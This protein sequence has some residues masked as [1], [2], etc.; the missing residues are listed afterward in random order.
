MLGGTRGRRGF[1]HGVKR[2][3]NPVRVEWITA[4]ASALFAT[5]AFAANPAKKAIQEFN[6]TPRAVR[7]DHPL[8]PVHH[9]DVP[10]GS[11]SYTVPRH[12]VAL[13]RT[14]RV[15][16][17]E[18]LVHLPT[19][20]ALNLESPAGDLKNRLRVTIATRD[21]ARI[22]DVVPLVLRDL[23]EFGQP[24]R[25]HRFVGCTTGTRR[26]HLATCNH[27]PPADSAALFAT[28]QEAELQ[29]F[30]PC[31][32]CFSVEAAPAIPYYAALRAAATT[33]ARLYERVHRSV[34]RDSIQ[35]RLQSLGDSLLACF[36]FAPLGFDYRFRLVQSEFPA[37]LSYPTGY[38]YLT[39]MLYDSLDSRWELAFLLA[40][41]IAHVEMH[42]WFP[43]PSWYEWYLR[44]MEIDADLAA[45]ACLWKMGAPVSVGRRAA[46]AL[47]KV[48]AF[49]D[50]LPPTR[51]GA[52]DSIPTLA[53][54]GKWLS[55]QQYFFPTAT[56]IGTDGDDEAL[57]HGTLLAAEKRDDHLVVLVAVEAS[58][59]L[60]Q[61]RIL[62]AL[63]M[64]KR[65]GDWMKF[66]IV[67]ASFFFPGTRRIVRA[68]HR[69]MGW[70][71]YWPDLEAN[72]GCLRFVTAPEIANECVED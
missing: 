70:P 35:A 21:S 33:D 67:G 3:T 6:E 44:D 63:E 22:E 12:L 38:V 31:A 10:G 5:A 19:F 53:E 14:G 56:G 20:S 50:E 52:N 65:G 26:F 29:G 51:S 37:T 46:L 41:E 71:R 72:A 2:H 13:A 1:R 16:R 4:L 17:V 39:D 43:Q 62:T 40:R 27:V 58:P 48:Q 45:L 47:R 25:T 30:Q 32:I 69:I 49:S 64:Q 55:S 15:F 23:F 61:A 24:L 68:Q 60:R 28:R 57:L 18:R 11:A 34:G 54:R 66:E 8:L 9:L 7:A 36:P 59:S 42:R